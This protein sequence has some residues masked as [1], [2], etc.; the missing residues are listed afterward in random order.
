MA[1][2][3][4]QIRLDALRPALA[5]AMAWVAGV[6]PVIAETATR[7]HAELVPHFSYPRPTY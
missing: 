1:H 5:S 2:D 4:T 7:T 3:S 6:G